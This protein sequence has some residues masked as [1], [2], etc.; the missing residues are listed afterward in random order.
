MKSASTLPGLP[1]SQSV[2]ASRLTRCLHNTRSSASFHISHNLSLSIPLHRPIAVLLAFL[3]ISPLNLPYKIVP[4][5]VHFTFIT[6]PNHLNLLFRVIFNFNSVQRAF[7]LE[8]Y[9]P[10]CNIIIVDETEIAFLR[11]WCWDITNEYVHL[12]D[13]VFVLT[14]AHSYTH[15]PIGIFM[16]SSPPCFSRYTRMQS[17]PGKFTI[18]NAHEAAS[19]NMGWSCN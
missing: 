16:I 8:D 9:A 4:A 10:F 18:F 15:T 13:H 17:A 2:G 11:Q 12:S 3:V 14:D 7:V 19:Y 1:Y 6:S 5:M